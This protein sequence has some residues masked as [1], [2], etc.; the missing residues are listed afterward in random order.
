[1][2]PEDAINDIQYYLEKYAISHEDWNDIETVI[3]DLDDAA[4]S[5]GQNT[6]QG[7]TSNYARNQS[8]HPR[9]ASPRS[10]VR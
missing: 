10:I 4:F 9:L 5:D 1:M 7:G 8:R 2:T 6:V 3:F